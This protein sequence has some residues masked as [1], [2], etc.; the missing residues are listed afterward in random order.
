MQYT[1]IMII[2]IQQ[3]ISHEQ[4][5]KHIKRQLETTCLQYPLVHLYCLETEVSQ[6]RNLKKTKF[7]QFPLKTTPPFTRYDNLCISLTR[8][9]SAYIVMK[10]YKIVAMKKYIVQCIC[11]INLHIILLTWEKSLSYIS[12]V[13]W[14]TLIL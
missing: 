14:Q 11:V 9:T 6:H 2:Y 4:S 7:Q 5:A 12:A 1:Q 3:C 13:F 8:D 10:F